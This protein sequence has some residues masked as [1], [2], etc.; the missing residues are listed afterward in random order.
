MANFCRTHF[1]AIKVCTGIVSGS[2]SFA[3]KHKFPL[4][5]AA[6]AAAGV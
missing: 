1:S 6:A 4:A 5:A 2:V 3:L